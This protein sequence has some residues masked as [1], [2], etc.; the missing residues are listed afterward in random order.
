MAL[1]KNEKTSLADI[2]ALYQPPA[3]SHKGQNGKLII[4]G[5]SR[6]FHGASLW[7]L[8]VGSR[9]VDMVYYS[10]VPENLKLTQKLKADL[11]DFISVPRE[12]V[13]AYIQE[14][15]A[16]LIG[17]GLVREKGTKSLT[18]KLIKKFPKKQWVIDAGSLQMMDKNLIPKNAILLPHA[19]E[20]VKLFGIK[21]TPENAAKM[22]KKNGCVILLKGPT[23][24]ICSPFKCKI[25]LTGNEGMTKGGTG[26]VLA[27]L[28]AAF[29]CKNDPFLAAC[30][31]AYINGLAG[32]RLK[33]RVGVYY[34]ASDLAEEIPATLKW[35]LNNKKN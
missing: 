25:N 19:R 31:G 26:D 5:G 35:S 30:A 3:N 13:E 6:L 23:D 10:S 15:E 17:P 18:E 4:I 2:K 32:N 16:I 12:E 8:K 27:G 11:Y 9:I 21:A 22:A 14:A 33:K 24:H 28:V 7:A 34:N 1:D 29:A 20:F